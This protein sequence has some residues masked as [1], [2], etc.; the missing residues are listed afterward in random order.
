MKKDEKLY[1]AIGDIDEEFINEAKPCSK[2]EALP[3]GKNKVKRKN[4]GWIVAVSLAAAFTLALAPIIYVY[5]LNSGVSRYSDSPYYS[6]IKT[7][8]EY[9]DEQEALSRP[10]IGD[11]WFGEGDD[12]LA[13]EPET[14]AGS[15]T[16]PGDTGSDKGESGSYEEV[17]DNQTAGV[18]E[19]DRI[20]RTDK[21]IYHLNGFRLAVYSIAGEDSALVGSYDLKKEKLLNYSV[22]SV[23]MYLSENGESV[24]VMI[25]GYDGNSGEKLAIIS[26]DTSVPQNIKRTGYVM[27]DGSYVTSRIADGKLLVVTNYYLNYKNVDYSK[28]ETFVPSAY[29]KDGE[30]LISADMI[31]SPDKLTSTRYTVVAAFDEATLE[32]LGYGAFLSYSD[33]VYVSE[34]NIYVTRGYTETE[35]IGDTV[36]NET[37]TDI[38][39]MS[40][41]D[42]LSVL[43]TI[44]VS[45]TVN[46]R[47]SLDEYD[48]MLR[49]V[50]SVSRYQYKESSNGNT[51]SAVFGD[52]V[53][54]AS[55]YIYDL[56]T[57]NMISSVECFAPMG[58]RVT[59]ARFDK[60]E[61]YVCTSIEL[62]DPVFFFDL[63]D[64]MNITSKDTGTISG[65]STS[66]IRFGDHLLGIGRE[67]WSDLKIEVYEETEDGIVSVDSYVKR[68][69]NYPTD[70]K[71]YY[72]N[73]EKG[74]VGL[75]VLNY[76][77][78]SGAVYDYL[79]IHFDGTSLTE[80]ASV[81]ID[82]SAGLDFIRG[83]VIDGYLYVLSGDL[84]VSKLDI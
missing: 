76:Y 61:A 51:S 14:G 18:I 55:L 46:D 6:L 84:D 69:V 50:T 57:L 16:A 1:R 48:G 60:T 53:M 10:S 59:S 78:Q 19:A 8:D 63:S 68:S 33:T 47:F 23:E 40:Y 31:L 2:K 45:G 73:R 11:I 13:G 67:S 22:N 15:A 21:Y 75:A 80:I 64:P 25:G 39:I 35:K 56:G 62:S 58:E 9:I 70:Y 49:A 17:T 24:T 32:S 29:T 72:I 36:K 37:K 83:V 20:K 65:F 77:T 52:S 82:N 28:P 71:C 5:I 34:N 3:S 12:L 26:L 27:L 81:N 4:T 38:S 79:L 43:G 54:S 30:I 74:L 7:L 44:K 41:A 66:L 42:S